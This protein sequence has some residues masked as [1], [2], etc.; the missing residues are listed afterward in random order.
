MTF[1]HIPPA[2]VEQMNMLPGFLGSGKV[3]NFY[4]PMVCLSCDEEAKFLFDADECRKSGTLPERSCT[5]C[6]GEMELD[7]IE[8]QY[9][10]FLR[11]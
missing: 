2:I 5:L 8:D 10:L 6:T 3:I 11:V 4:A 9:T 7:E 1:V